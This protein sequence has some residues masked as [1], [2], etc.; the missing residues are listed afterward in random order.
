M[1]KKSKNFFAVLMLLLF[2]SVISTYYR[3][4]ILK[5]FNFFTDEEVFYEEL[6]YY[7]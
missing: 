1:D 4:V 5:D 3:Y 2:L 6:E 7:E